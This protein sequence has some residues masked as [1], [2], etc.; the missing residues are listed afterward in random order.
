MILMLLAKTHPRLFAEEGPQSTAVFYNRHVTGCLKFA[1]T[2]GVPYASA[3]DVFH[4]AFAKVYW[5]WSNPDKAQ[6]TRGILVPKAFLYKAVR[7]SC[8]NFFAH[9]NYQQ[10]LKSQLK[11]LIRRAVSG[12]KKT[13]QG[14]QQ[15]LQSQSQPPLEVEQHSLWKAFVE[16]FPAEA[17]VLLLL[18]QGIAPEDLPDVVGP[19]GKTRKLGSKRYRVVFSY[20]ARDT[21]RTFLTD[22]TLTGF[23]KLYPKK[24]EAIERVEAGTKPE[25]LPPKFGRT[26]VEKQSFVDDAYRKRQRFCPGDTA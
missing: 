22:R 14:S 6:A 25:E 26:K 1:Q 9:E 4:E 18:A 11:Q 23:Q 17:E 12:W 7:N 3:Q 16:D 15:P 13:P 24:A 2:L 5:S 8:Y 10:N 20:K 19:E 21:L